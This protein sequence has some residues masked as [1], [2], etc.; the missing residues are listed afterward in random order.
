MT[1]PIPQFKNDPVIVLVLSLLTCG[2]YLIYWNIKAAQVL[3][4]AAEK[5][6]ISQPI[7]IYLQGVAYLLMYISIIWQEKKAYQ[8]YMKKQE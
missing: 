1:Q 8:K 6:I 3:N 7:A 4:A 2:L 5:E